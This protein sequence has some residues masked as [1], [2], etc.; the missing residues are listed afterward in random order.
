MCSP[1]P[2]QTPDVPHQWFVRGSASVLQVPAP[3]A[4][5]VEAGE[6]PAEVRTL[7]H[8]AQRAQGV[9]QVR[10]H[11]HLLTEPRSLDFYEGRSHGLHVGAVI[12][13]RNSP[14]ADWIFKFICV[15][16]SI[17]NTAE[18]VLED[19]SEAL[20]SHHTVKG[21]HKHSLLRVE[22]RGGALDEIR[23]RNNP[24]NNLDFLGTHP[25]AGNLVIVRV[26]GRIILAALG[27][28][29]DQISLVLKHLLK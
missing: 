23:I 25:P 6:I 7:L 8:A 4:E 26:P 27:Q 16:P 21:A 28:E 13:E 24:R 10:V 5:V 9:L 2:G 14:G 29:V 17:D 1:G 20:C 3:V 22:A 12:V 11:L 19:E 18:Q 15:Q